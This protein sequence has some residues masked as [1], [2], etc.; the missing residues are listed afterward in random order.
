M[1][2]YRINYLNTKQLNKEVKRP[3]IKDSYND[4]THKA[5]YNHE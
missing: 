3:K 5:Q 2:F 4:K 1:L